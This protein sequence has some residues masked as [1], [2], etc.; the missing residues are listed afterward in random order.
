MSQ[1]DFLC[2]GHH[3]LGKYLHKTLLALKKAKT[4]ANYCEIFDKKQIVE[5]FRTSVI[6]VSYQNSLIAYCSY[7][8][9]KEI[10][11]FD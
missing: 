7:L 5:R 8:L 10:S 6:L 1:I 11:A 3:W 9:I 4:P 2:Y